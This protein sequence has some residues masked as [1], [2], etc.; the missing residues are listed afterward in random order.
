MRLH[1][2][3]QIVFILESLMTSVSTC[4]SCPHDVQS[5]FIKDALIGRGA[6]K[7]FA[8]F[9]TFTKEMIICPNLFNMQI[10]F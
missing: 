10:K 9:T 5:R 1:S 2:M 7:S 6:K 8:F 3:F 4:P